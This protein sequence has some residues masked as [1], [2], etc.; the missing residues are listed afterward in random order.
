MVLRRVDK[1]SRMLVNQRYDRVTLYYP[2]RTLSFCRWLAQSSA[3]RITLTMYGNPILAPIWRV[4]GSRLG[5]LKIELVSV[6]EAWQLTEECTCLNT[7][8]LG[9]LHQENT[10]V[11]LRLSL[12]LCSTLEVLS[13]KT[14]QQHEKSNNVICSL[15]NLRAFSR[16]RRLTIDG[17]EFTDSRDLLQWLPALWSLKLSY[18]RAYKRIAP[19]FA[20]PL[21][22]Y[23][24]CLR[25]VDIYSDYRISQIES[26]ALAM[27]RVLCAATNLEE[28]LFPWYLCDCERYVDIFCDHWANLMVRL[29]RLCVLRLPRIYPLDDSPYCCPSASH[30]FHMMCTHS[31]SLI[32]LHS[33]SL[34]L[35]QTDLEN[36]LLMPRLRYWEIAGFEDAGVLPY[37]FRVTTLQANPEFMPRLAGWEDTPFMSAELLLHLLTNLDVLFIDVYCWATPNLLWPLALSRSFLKVLLRNHWEKMP[38]V[39]HNSPDLK[40]IVEAERRKSPAGTSWLQR[41]FPNCE[42]EAP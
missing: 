7:L 40:R 15:E 19:S 2:E 23:A 38:L 39:Y 16:L 37:M 17:C 11:S 29:L 1:C 13:L 30:A 36:L 10:S 34:P 33:M 20:P 22:N 26:C 12:K 27:A 21:G 5:V 6:Q 28:L 32:A 24:P 9:I 41:N 14:M 4:A 25:K 42:K 31:T 8:K 18:T 35:H 3:S